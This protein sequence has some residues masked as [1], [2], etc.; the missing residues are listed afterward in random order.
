MSSFTFA[1]AMAL[2]ALVFFY[3]SAKAQLSGKYTIDPSKAASATNYLNFRSAVTDLD[4]GKRYDGGTANGK[5]VSGPVVF[6]VANGTYNENVHLFT[7]PGTSA[8]NTVLFESASGDSSKVI[9]TFPG[10]NV[11]SL[12]GIFT[13]FTLFFDDVSQVSF[14][15][16]TIAR[17]VI[18]TNNANYADVVLIEGSDSITITNCK[19]T[20][21]TYSSMNPSQATS[22][23]IILDSK[24]YAPNNILIQNN[25]ILYA[26]T[27][28]NMQGNGVNGNA[29]NI[30]LDGNIT[31]STGT[32]NDGINIM[33]INHLILNR[34]YF[35]PGIRE[36]STQNVSVLKFTNNIIHGRIM[37][38]QDG[39][40]AAPVLIENNVF[41]NGGFESIGDSVVN[42]YYNTFYNPSLLYLQEPD[43]I[44]FANNIV[45]DSAGSPLYASVKT[46]SDYN[47][48][49]YNPGNYFGSYNS[50]NYTS[51]KAWQSGTGNDIH[52]QE[53]NTAFASPTYLAPKNPSMNFGT[54]ISGITTD[55]NGNPRDPNHP[56]VGAYNIAYMGDTTLCKGTCAIFTAPVSG[57]SYLW[58]TGE[59]TKSIKY[60]P[61]FFGSAGVWLRVKYGSALSDTIHFQFFVTVTNATC[62]WP[63][64]ANYDGKVDMNDLLS[65]GVA[66]GDTGARRQNASDNWFGQSCDDWSKSFTNGVNHKNADCDGNGVVDSSDLS[67]ISLNY[68]KTHLKTAPVATGNPNDPPL[69][70]AFSKDSAMAG[71]TVQA[72][73]SLGSKA[74]PA[75]DVYGVAISVGYGTASPAKYN[76]ADFSNSWLG[77]Y[78]KNMVSLIVNDSVN[79]AINIG[80]TRTDHN[81]ASG[82]GE[83]GAVSITMPDNL[84]GKREVKQMVKF[85]I[86]TYKAISANEN[87]VP[88]NPI[89]DS[90]LLYQYKTSG[91]APYK[92]NSSDF[93]IYPNPANDVLH[94][95]TNNNPVNT[96]NIEDV[97]GN[98]VY[99]SISSGSQQVDLPISTLS[100]GIYIINI[101]TTKGMIRSRFVK[102]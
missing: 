92:F 65:V 89:G 82:Y 28:I 40:N 85:N 6:N 31:D 55:I 3:Y 12:N 18:N 10:S 2:T 21:N 36:I 14:K 95:Q 32:P 20:G 13:D 78:H 35:D 7:I 41:F 71:D 74:I 98:I 62:V 42:M 23:N 93:K 5:G 34:N 1:K 9:I 50:S 70:I 88:L 37:S 66:Y 68:S 87:D 57:S 44:N 19:I 25:L 59:T 61:T 54:P 8:T 22:I 99:S 83:I 24:S 58:S 33:A 69:N 29:N 49:I 39:S 96:V 84:G 64:D 45:F 76:S 43:L 72:V 56:T 81:N 53:I 46:M 60:C 91:I 15:G 47:D 101:S 27:P 17:P 80:I 16:L 97:L 100:K 86:E 11:M 73:I 4:S 51:L 38:D 102:E 52:S 48:Y 90:I 63:G 26:N 67:V 75:S 79:Q 77:T 30:V 94:V